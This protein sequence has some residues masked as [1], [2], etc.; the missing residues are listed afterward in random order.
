MACSRLIRN[1]WAWSERWYGLDSRQFQEM[2][3]FKIRVNKKLKCNCYICEACTYNDNYEKLKTDKNNK[4]IFEDICVC[5]CGQN[6]T[7]KEFNRIFNDKK[8]VEE[9]RELSEERY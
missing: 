4:F 2:W 1:Y 9:R 3:S 7:A 8:F 5:P 6:L